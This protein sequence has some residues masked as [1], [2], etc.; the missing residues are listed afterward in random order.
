MSSP[1]Q[2]KPSSVTSGPVVFEQT[3]E[4][5]M[6]NVGDNFPHVG[7][8]TLRGALVVS[9][10]NI[11]D[12]ISFLNRSAE[13]ATTPEDH[14]KFKG[15]HIEPY[16]ITSPW[17]NDASTPKATN[18]PGSEVSTKPLAEA[19]R[20]QRLYQKLAI[21][22]NDAG[23]LS[24]ATHVYTTRVVSAKDYIPSDVELLKSQTKKR[25]LVSEEPYDG[26]EIPEDPVAKKSVATEPKSKT[27]GKSMLKPSAK[28]LMK[29]NEVK[30]K[31]AAR[32]YKRKSASARLRQ[33]LKVIQTQR[34]AALASQK[35]R[36]A[37][38]SEDEIDEEQILFLPLQQ[39]TTRTETGTNPTSH[40]LENANKVG[41]ATRLE[42]QHQVL[43]T[44][45]QIRSSAIRNN[46]PPGPDI[47][48]L[49]DATPVKVT[50]KHNRL[51]NKQDPVPI[52]MKRN[53]KSLGDMASTMNKLFSD[54]GAE[55]G[56][57]SEKYSVPKEA[58]GRTEITKVE[59]NMTTKQEVD[60]Q[61]DTA[62]EV[63]ERPAPEV[64]TRN[65]DNSPMGIFQKQK[66]LDSTIILSKRQRAIKQSSPVYQ[67]LVRRSPRIAAKKHTHTKITQKGGEGKSVISPSRSSDRLKA[68]LTGTQIV[69]NDTPVSKNLTDDYLARKQQ[70]IS[71]GVQGARNQGPSS[72]VKESANRATK[73]TPEAVV[74]LI[75]K[76]SSELKRKMETTNL[77]ETLPMKKQKSIN[78]LEDLNVQTDDVQ[79]FTSS[80]PQPQQLPPP[81]NIMNQD[82]R[83][84]QPPL[85]VPR[86][87]SGLS[88]PHSQKSH[89]NENGS[90]IGSSQVDHISKAKQKL[91]EDALVKPEI[92]EAQSPSPRAPLFGPKLKLSGI[93]KARPSSPAEVISH[94]VPH[95]KTANGLYK[96]IRTGEVNTNAYF[97]CT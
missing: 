85:L 33:D 90:P 49:Y 2:S 51:G 67:S 54:P 93:T 87:S 23:S 65:E 43:E 86:R 59:L 39:E 47:D 10:G 92:E 64:E 41:F 1:I 42:K 97:V 68:E 79:G 95:Q 75:L 77:K 17:P 20:S 88:R 24:K 82:S 3:M 27:L 53:T 69:E 16:S 15:G 84:S 22:K 58:S 29:A 4:D 57:S 61:I 8:P 28:P 21:I 94:Y 25:K 74:S 46:D 35:F 7:E 36:D 62:Y 19:N 60:G 70:I 72:V 66:A 63:I 96:G 91:W 56:K 34:S 40:V 38:M 55:T 52:G 37:D 44:Q 80:P 83:S 50:K 31:P 30:P 12:A 6:R 45:R 73:T 32:S 11:E 48:D 76:E 13:L 5:K 9:K 89:V 78:S 81:G 18:I 14:V 26:F 71:F